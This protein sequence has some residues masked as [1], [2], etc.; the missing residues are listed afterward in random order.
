MNPMAIRALEY[1]KNSGGGAT[2]EIFKDDHAPVGQA[3][4]D[5][6][7]DCVLVDAMGRIF[8]NGKGQKIIENNKE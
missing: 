5:E 1:V 6:I 3:L 2:E 7:K 8:L 4:W